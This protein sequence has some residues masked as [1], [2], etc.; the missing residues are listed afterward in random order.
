MTDE[1]V[2]EDARQAILKQYQS[3]TTNYDGNM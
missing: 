2:N 3:F 1:L